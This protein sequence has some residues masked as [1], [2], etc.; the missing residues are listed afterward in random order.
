MRILLIDVNY[1]KS[2]TG[3]IVHD[4][5]SQLTADRHVVKVLY[6]RG[7]SSL[8]GVGEKISSN[9]E[10]YF[11]ALMT[12]I[13]GLVGC[14][15]YFATRRLISKIN[16]FRPDVIHLHELHGYYINIQSIVEYLKLM[17]IPVIW[18]FHCEFMYT[19]KCG[20]A[21]DCEQWK[22]ECMKCPQLHEYPASLYFDFTNFM[23]N[24]KKKY[25]G[26]FDNLY[27][28]SPSVWLLNRVQ[29]SFLKNKTLSVIHN[30]I[31]T[32]DIFHPRAS[33]HLVKKHGLA[34]KKIILAVA[35]GIMDERKGGEWVLKLASQFDDRYCFIM[36]GLDGELHAPPRNVIPIR[37]TEN[38]IQLAEYYSMADI[39][40]ICSKRENFPTTCLES[41][42]CG[43]PVIGF[44]EG[45]TAE[46]APVP[47]GRFVSY[48]DLEA[49][50]KLIYGFFRGEI[51]YK[52][53][54]ECRDFAVLNYSKE[55]MYL[56]YLK[57]FQESQVGQIKC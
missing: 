46:T 17:R 28:V 11:H 8:D 4:L 32:L 10:I 38:Q 33:A 51:E 6:G 43:T 57:L 54:Q 45:G 31:D 25:M 48:G 55:A 50:E 29:K 30:G 34:G 20:Y 1:K 41:L 27:I 13:S 21:Y 42:A 24:Q 7:S 5:A 44:D 49:L 36:I 12:R 14:F 18:T 2:S 40:L 56:N 35:P 53:S 47:Y 16:K 15:S 23:F 22:T 39:F 52:S 19:G 26:N 3:K 9:V 37:R